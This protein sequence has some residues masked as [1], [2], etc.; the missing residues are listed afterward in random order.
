M[1]KKTYVLIGASS[2][3]SLQFIK[4]CKIKNKDLLLISRISQPQFQ[5][6]NQLLIKDYL[7]D[8]NLIFNKIKELNECIVIFFN[9][10]LYENRPVQYPSLKEIKKTEKIN[11]EIPY[12]LTVKLNKECE[13]IKKYVYISSIAAAKLRYKNYI[14]GSNKKKLENKI[15]EMDLSSFL[16]IRFGKVFTRMSEGHKTPPF[17]VSPKIAAELIFKNLG[18]EG[19]VYPKLGLKVISMILKVTPSFIIR[20]LKI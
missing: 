19:L 20:F 5:N 15:N 11:F 4:L 12:E 17:S 13:N 7:K 9:G 2:E 8:K 6:L 1:G 18:K 14:Y 10:A 3:I 16:I